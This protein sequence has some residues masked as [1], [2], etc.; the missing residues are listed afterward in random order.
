MKKLLVLLLGGL[1]AANVAFAVLDPDANSMGIYFDLNAD[2]VEA[3]GPM[4]GQFSAHVILTNPD[5]P[6]LDGYEFGYIMG[7]NS[8]VMGTTLMGLGPSDFGGF[9]GNHIVA[10]GGPMP[11]SPATNLCT[12]LILPMD[13][14]P[15]YFYLGGAQPNSIPGS[16]LP[17]VFDGSVIMPI[18]LSTVWPNDVSAIYNG[19]GVVTTEQ[20]SWGGVKALYR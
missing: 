16:I 11:T 3:V 7:G 10:L 9:P 2:V 20:A 12:L 5:F 17:A 14:L 6:A 4:F 19:T 18:G 1:L 15:I 13:L 8:M